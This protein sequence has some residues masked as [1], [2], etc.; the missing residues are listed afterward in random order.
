MHALDIVVKG[1]RFCFKVFT[2][3]L[4]V[5]PGSLPV[6]VEATCHW[7]T[8]RQRPCI[9]GQSLL[10]IHFFHLQSMVLV[11]RDD[12]IRRQSNV[13]VQLIAVGRLPIK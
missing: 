3:S 7:I 5:P 4:H 6:S 1:L 12:L 2:R 9:L 10:W 11:L 8:F 13:S